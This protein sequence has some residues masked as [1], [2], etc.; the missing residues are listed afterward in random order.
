MVEF[1]FERTQAGFNVSKAFSVGK[2]GEGHAKELIV[3]GEFSDS[4]VAM[5]TIDAFLEFMAGKK[6][7]QLREN[8]TANVHGKPSFPG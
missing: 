2:L 6:V 7:H 8:S 5:V 1:I 4:P 3:A